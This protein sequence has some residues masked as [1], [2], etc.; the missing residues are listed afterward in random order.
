M[1]R[2]RSKD[3]MG[4]ASSKFSRAIGSVAMTAAGERSLLVAGDSPGDG[5]SA[6]AESFL[7]LFADLSFFDFF[8]LG[9]PVGRNR[10]VEKR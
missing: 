1:P 7:G 9:S 3:L 10:E 8:N 5:E 6:M 2:A 4:A